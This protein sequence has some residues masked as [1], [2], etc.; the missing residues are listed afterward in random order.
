MPLAEFVLGEFDAA[1]ALGVLDLADVGAAPAWTE[2]AASTLAACEEMA[3]SSELA[4]TSV[5][6]EVAA[7]IE[8]AAILLGATD[9]D[10]VACGHC[11]QLPQL[12]R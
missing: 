7:E 3:A 8:D 9:A 2:V 5:T 1:T 12:P 6:A 4:G 10:A 11:P